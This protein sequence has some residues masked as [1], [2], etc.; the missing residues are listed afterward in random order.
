MHATEKQI[1]FRAFVAAFVAS[2]IFAEQ[3]ARAEVGAD[4]RLLTAE[5]IQTDY[6]AGKYTTVELTTAYLKQIKTFDP[7][8]NAWVTLNPAALADA[9]KVDAARGDPAVPKGPLFGVPIAIKDPMDVAGLRTT[10][11]SAAFTK[12]KGGVEMVP[13][14]DSPLVARL[15]DAG[16]IILGKTNVPDFSRSGTNSTSSA[17]GPTRNPFDRSRVPGGSSGGTGVAVATGMAVMGMAEE[18]GSSIRN[19]A[20]ANGIVG[21]R[22]SLD[23]IASTGVYPLN[24]FRD[25]VGPHA[26]TVTDAVAMFDV[27]AGADPGDPRTS[28]GA[29]S[30]PAGGYAANLDAGSLKGARIAVWG[31]GYNPAE[32]AKL[33]PETKALFDRELQ[34]LRD[35]GATLVEDP[36]AGTEWSATVAKVGPATPDS[37]FSYFVDQYLE[38]LGPAA[39]FNSVAEYEALTGKDFYAI[40]NVPAETSTEN[41]FTRADLTGF[42]TARE[43]LRDMWSDILSSNNLDGLVMPQLA[44]KVP[45]LASGDP[46][47]ST[48]GAAPNIMGIPGITVPGGFYDD[49]TPFSMYFLGERFDELTVM[50]LGYAYEQATLH[51]MAPTL[52]P[53]PPA[54]WAGLTTMA[55]VAAAH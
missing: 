43:E 21:I 13:A 16:A 15:R 55:G 7:F 44:E 24:G 35:A 53:L 11:G 20:S 2:S 41:P 10:V 50:N 3:G 1:R 22:P 31:P 28:V 23:L 52:V 42:F 45:T 6:A 51:R 29:P 38:R 49:G 40:P 36:F 27:L 32:N 8:Y 26:K 48:P 39:A 18:T 4:L 30:I 37:G 19:P 9:A 5:Q 12:E 25:V 46:L 47:R 34:V 33:T 54:A 14:T 17:I